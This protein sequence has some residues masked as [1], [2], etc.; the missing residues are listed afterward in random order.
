MSPIDFDRAPETNSLN[1][2]KISGNFQKS[3]PF[4][5]VLALIGANSRK[6]SRTLQAIP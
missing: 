4:G 1:T 5:A 3:G 6:D 2:G